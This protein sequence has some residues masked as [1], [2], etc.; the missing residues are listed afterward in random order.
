MQFALLC[1]YSNRAGGAGFSPDQ[2]LYFANYLRRLDWAQHPISVHT[3]RNSP[4]ERYADLLGSD[5]FE[6]TSIQFSIENAG[7]FVEDWRTN[8]RDAGRPWI[9][10]LD[11]VGPAGVGLIDTNADALRRDVLYPVY[12]SGGQLEWNF[13]YHTLPLG[14]DVSMPFNK[15]NRSFSFIGNGIDDLL[16]LP[17]TEYP[18]LRIKH[19]PFVVGHGELVVGR[20]VSVAV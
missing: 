6:A 17:V 13:G 9:V 4:D 15:L 1:H 12:F 8:S 20:S 5:L 11:E 7:R 19:L 10:D 2:H 16:C 18:A 3:R 14:G